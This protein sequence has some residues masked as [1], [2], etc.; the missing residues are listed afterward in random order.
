MALQ[1]PNAP[2]VLQD[3]SYTFY[4]DTAARDKTCDAQQGDNPTNPASLPVQLSRYRAPFSQMF[5]A[6][7]ELPKLAQYTV[8]AD[9]QNLYFSEGIQLRSDDPT[10]TCVREFTV[11]QNQ[12]PI[13][14]VLPLFLNPI[15]S[16]Q[17]E[18]TTTPILEFASEHGLE[19]LNAC[20]QNDPIRLISTNV[21]LADA[22]ATSFTILD[23]ISVQLSLSAPVSWTGSP[24]GYLYAPS[25]TSPSQL[26]CMVT[27]AFHVVAPGDFSVTYDPLTGLFSF[28]VLQPN[29]GITCYNPSIPACPPR[30][31]NECLQL[32]GKNN[33]DQIVIVVNNSPCLPFIMG[34]G[35]C[36]GQIVVPSAPPYTA[37]GQ[38]GFCACESKAVIQPGNYDP[39]S[40][41]S[42]LLNQLNRFYFPGGCAMDPDAE[43]PFIFADACGVCH[44]ISIPYGLYSP[45][46][47]AAYLQTQ[48]NALDAGHNYVV[49]Y[50]A[51]FGFC[52]TADLGTVF[53]LEFAEALA[54]DV[55]NRLGFTNNS[56]RGRSQYCSTNPLNV[57][58]KNCCVSPRYLDSVYEVSYNG[59]TQQFSFVVSRPPAINPTSVVAGAAGTA[60]VTTTVAHGLQ[61]GSVIAMG[62]FEFTVISV[63]DAFTFT[64]ELGSV[65]LPLPS[66]CFSSSETPILNLY[67]APSPCQVNPIRPEVF[68]FLRQDV[69]ATDASVTDDLL[70][71]S[72]SLICLDPPPYLLLQCS[73]PNN[74]VTKNSHT[75]GNNQTLS[76][77]LA[78]ILIYPS[79]KFERITNTNG[80]LQELGV[81][82]KMTLTLLN[83]DHT[84]YKFHGTNWS[85]S[86]VFLVSEGVSKLIC[87]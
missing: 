38:A 35:A 70:V 48:M 77:I 33:Q 32:P 7:L 40:L 14:A 59:S 83:P 34:F 75:N 15:V 29:L 76:F 28:R 25:I 66:N 64:I 11:M 82:T 50:S 53:S 36:G 80:F 9:W 20:P 6:T 5:L 22:L 56:F 68:G 84:P 19:I 4:F 31:A 16:V 13:T 51:T 52:F 69:L 26:A 87:Y 79:L 12:V 3:S 86:M 74:L 57:P 63:T 43:K 24:Y 47:L 54:G 30:F 46:N 62:G 44:T 37:I 39:M 2:N 41:G 17:N 58:L 27:A 81:I 60:V 42:A 71:K 18:G 73:F 78:K 10:Q 85:G 72:N 55:A 21:P 61:V 67:F 23:P 65:A 45:E 1:P 49:T 8:E